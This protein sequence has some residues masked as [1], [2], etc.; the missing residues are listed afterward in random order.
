MSQPT[1]D[2]QPDV[3]EPEAKGAGGANGPPPPPKRR[4]W[5]RRLVL[6]AA[7]LLALLLLLVAAAPFALSTPAGR[8]L[9]LSLANARL[10]GTI[11]VQSLSLSWFGHNELRELRV[12]DPQGREV[13]SVARVSLSR[14]L[15]GLATGPYT[16]GEAAIDSPRATLYVD[17]NNDISLVQALRF[18]GAA[19]P[20]AES[21]AGPPPG[22]RGALR[23]RDGAL[24]L[25]RPGG[26]TLEVARI[27]AQADID[28]FNKLA[29]SF[30][31]ALAEGGALAAEARIQNLFRDGRLDLE[32]AEGEVTL[33]TRGPADLAKITAALAPDAAVAGAVELSIHGRASAGE[34]NAD[35]RASAT[36]LIARRAEGASPLNASL[37]GRIRRQGESLAG[38]ADLAG[39]AGTIQLAATYRPSQSAIAVGVDQ[40]LAAILNGEPL[41][42]PE[43]TLEA[44]GALDLVKLD[45]ALP[46]LLPLREGQRL[47][48]GEVR[49]ERVAVRG[50][51]QPAASG[52]VEL[53]NVAGV[54]DGQQIRLEPIA[55]SVDAALEPGRGVQVRRAEMKSSFAR[56]EAAGDPSALRADFDADLA[57]LHRE[58]GQFVDLSSVQLAGQLRGS[59]DVKR[60]E[61]ERV[62]ASLSASGSQIRIAGGDRT[63]ALARGTLE[64]RGGLRMPGGKPALVEVSKA[65]LNLDDRVQLAAGGSFDLAT[66]GF[67]VTVEMSRGDLGY[68][69]ERAAA[70]G[71]PELARYGGSVALTAR[72]ERR[73]AG[74][75]IQGDGSLLASDLTADGASLI[76]GD[77]QLGWSGVSFAPDGKTAAVASASLVSSAARIDAST[78]HWRTGGTIEASADVRASA[79]LAK[80]FAAVARVA[81]LDSPP[82]VGGKLSLELKAA[83]GGGRVTLTGAGGVDELAVGAGEQ[84]VRE[85][86]VDL[87]FGATLDSSADRLQLERAS[88]RSGPLTADA[89]GTIEKLGGD[90][91]LALKC[92]YDA[93][94]K[95]LT[96]LLHE[97]APDTVEVVALDGRSEAGFEV[98][99]PL[100]TAGARPGFRGVSTEV[101]VSWSTAQLLG[102]ELGA[103]TLKP[104]LKGGR[105]TLPPTSISAAEGKINLAGALDL[106]PDDPTLLI[107]GELRLLEGV[108]VTPLLGS[109]LL[110]RINPIFLH[111]TEVEGSVFLNVAKLRAPLGASLNRQ[112]SGAGR[113]DLRNVKMRPGGP[114]AELLELGGLG[115]S[116]KYTV[117]FGKL[118]FRLRDGRVEYQDFR[119]KFP[120]SFDLR[121][122]GSVGLDDTLDLL[123]SIPVRPALLKR[124]GVSESTLQFLRNFEKA[125][126]EV[127]LAGTREQPRI[128]L[129]K[130]NVEKLVRDL[131]APDSPQDTL[132]NILRGLQGGRKPEPKPDRPARPQTRPAPGKKPR[133]P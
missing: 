129:S 47:T 79:D 106:A 36:R 70:I 46:G 76:D 74:E 95:E 110:S 97:L 102:V 113:L 82:R 117:E 93:Q 59:L 37:T 72:A 83:S 22:L 32:H 103:A 27:S 26:E 38:E 25:V 21:E 1:E 52:A 3:A 33:K 12:L 2:R 111:M 128:D 69:A 16:L 53:R 100:R 107:D 92:R 78:I 19:P 88:V 132:N 45:R 31:L 81:K 39:D 71:V 65:D 55:L 61:A 94:W 54:Q 28:T 60:S 7:G 51:K 130:V 123:V 112:G 6:V 124:L 96:T 13:L 42:A 120:Q 89:S 30:E 115:A 48:A 62:D 8:G 43:F 40:V 121:F 108:K 101:P 44:S 87:G 99:G 125:R 116:E 57:R 34:L 77:A 119:V 85:A 75:P 10:A 66:Q 15:L 20:P 17:A 9:V 84:T 86:R 50:G 56:L 133:R 127:P 41:D 90:A 109:S 114:L 35:L 64:S 105:L 58:L 49:I 122:S 63:F 23:L 67:S 118:D 131:L 73:A 68:A 4:R 98:R 14:S 18:K 126:I 104:A 24:K 29:G 5:R 80:T 91:V 11:D